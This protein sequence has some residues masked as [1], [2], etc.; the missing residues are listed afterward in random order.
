VN[1]YNNVSMACEKCENMVWVVVGKCDMGRSA[2][3][4]QG[5]V[6]EMS[7]NFTLP[8]CVNNWVIVHENCIAACGRGGGMWLSLAAL[9]LFSPD[10][11]VL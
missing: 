1:T 4:S 7:G 9:F 6:K 2:V 10:C 5:N 8:A 11:N 3:K